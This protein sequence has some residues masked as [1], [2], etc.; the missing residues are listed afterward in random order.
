MD[1]PVKPA[2]IPRL[3]SLIDKTLFI[4]EANSMYKNNVIENRHDEMEEADVTSSPLHVEPYPPRP[5]P[6]SAM[7]IDT[8][9]R[10][11][12]EGVYDR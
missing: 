12:M 6:K 5:P 2:P 1:K 9:A 11:R 3:S 4:A 8:P 10:H 7:T